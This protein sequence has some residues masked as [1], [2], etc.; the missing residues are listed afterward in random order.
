MRAGVGIDDSAGDAVVIVPN[1][2]GSAEHSLHAA[3]QALAA[4]KSRRAIHLPA[5]ARAALGNLAR[6][7]G[8]AKGLVST[9]PDGTPLRRS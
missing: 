8:T 5:L 9:N 6:G 2:W 1:A 7:G 3:K 4:A